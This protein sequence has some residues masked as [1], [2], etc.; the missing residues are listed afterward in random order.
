MEDAWAGPSVWLGGH[1]KTFCTTFVRRSAFLASYAVFPVIGINNLIISIA[2]AGST[3]PPPPCD[4]A[5]LPAAGWPR[6]LVRY[7][8]NTY[9]G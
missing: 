4:K 8:G 6:S 7:G 2:C 9:R 1:G 3:P 5:D